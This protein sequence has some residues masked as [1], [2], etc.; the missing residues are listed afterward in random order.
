MGL[1]W[2]SHVKKLELSLSRK[3]MA[4]YTRPRWEKKVNSILA[5]K[6]F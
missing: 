4:I 6:G 1:R 2:R 5:G 3:W